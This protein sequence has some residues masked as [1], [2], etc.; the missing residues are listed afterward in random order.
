MSDHDGEFFQIRIFMEINVLQEYG[1]EAGGRE[2]RSR[3]GGEGEE[4]LESSPLL[5]TSSVKI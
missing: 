2:E 4:C 3:M 1:C 5:I